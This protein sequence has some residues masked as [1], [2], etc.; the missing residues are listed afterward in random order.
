MR[1]LLLNQCFHPD[2][3]STA[4]HLSDFG[5]GLVERGHHVTAIASRRAYDRPEQRFPARETWKGIEIRRLASTGFGKGAKWKRAADFGS[6]SAACTLRLL[7]AGRYDAV[8]A[9]TSPPLV[10]Y[11][12]AWFCRLRGA[13]LF[14]WVMDMNPDEALAAGWLREGSL[15]TRALEVMSRFSLR[16]SHRIIAL[17]RFMRDRIVAK[18]IPAERVAVIPPWAHDEA[19]HFD[20]EGRAKFRAAHGLTDKFVVMYSGNHSPVHPLTTLMEAARQ[21]AGDP[22]FAFCFVGGGS[23]HPRVRKFAEQ[24]GLKNILCLPYQPLNELAGSLSAADLHTVVLGEP[25]V[26]MIH[27]CK[28]YNILT[29]GAPVLYVGPEPSHLADILASMD[30]SPHTARVAHGRPDDAAAQIRRIAALGTR[31]DKELFAR[32]AAR[33]SVHTL[34]PQQVKLLE[35]SFPSPG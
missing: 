33:F 30:G 17:D 22:R 12:A 3:A 31:G 16:Q 14:Y 5:V 2:V 4:Q 19:V 27:P 9:L 23:E 35:D 26:G 18:G 34:R 21:L 1:I 11:L 24:H 29:V 8:V 13:K 6:F 7:A 25:F 10:S 15:P 20:A 32:T 28:I